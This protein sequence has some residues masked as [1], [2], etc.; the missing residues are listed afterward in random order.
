MVIV[1]FNNRV[2]KTLSNQC[3]AG[4]LH[5]VVCSVLYMLVYL[6]DSYVVAAHVV[7]NLANFGKA[8][9]STA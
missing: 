1:S 2:C 6:M 3:L 5:V 4:L 8:A 9:L 7:E